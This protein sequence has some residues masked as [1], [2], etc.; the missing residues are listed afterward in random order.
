MVAEILQGILLFTL[1]LGL[2]RLTPLTS[3]CCEEATATVAETVE[4][5]RPNLL[6]WRSMILQHGRRRGRTTHSEIFES[7]NST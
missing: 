5:L 3:L 1:G 4:M 7:S 2:P 6:L